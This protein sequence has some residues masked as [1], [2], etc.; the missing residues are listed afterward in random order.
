M[1]FLTVLAASAVLATKLE[2]RQFAV[3]DLPMSVAQV[4]QGHAQKR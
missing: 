3:E 1:R 4:Q 2:K